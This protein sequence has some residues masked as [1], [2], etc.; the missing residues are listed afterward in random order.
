MPLPDT[1]WARGKCGFKLIQYMG[2]SVPVVASRVGANIEIVEE[3]KSG[4]LASGDDEWLDAL[5]TLAR[6]ADLRR[7]MGRAGRERVESRYSL[8]AVQGTIESEIREAAT[9][10]HRT[11]D[12]RVVEAFGREWSRFD[13]S[14][15]S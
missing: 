7:S 5:E 4:L 2:C 14:T 13:Q 10:S 3:E 12:A 6:D 11:Y 1:P 8:S 9:R 15:L